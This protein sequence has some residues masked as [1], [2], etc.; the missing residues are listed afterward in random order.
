[1][2]ADEDDRYNNMT[3]MVKWC[4]DDYVRFRQTDMCIGRQNIQTDQ[5]DRHRHTDRHASAPNNRRTEKGRFKKQ[6]VILTDNYIQATC[7]QQHQP[8]TIR[9]L[10]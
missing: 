5:T 9:T 10:Y 8:V 7:L 1:V 6:R 4:D 2:K 3:M